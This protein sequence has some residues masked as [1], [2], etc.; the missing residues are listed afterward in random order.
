MMNQYENMNAMNERVM[1]VAFSYKKTMTS[2][3]NIKVV[4]N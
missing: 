3:V 2:L 4:E 1:G